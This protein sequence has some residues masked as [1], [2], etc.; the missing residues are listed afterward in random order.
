LD[1]RRGRL[2]SILGPADPTSDFDDPEIS[3]HHVG[4]AK[5]S[6]RPLERLEVGPRHLDIEIFGDQ[7]Q[8]PIAHAATYEARRR[9][10]G[11]TASSIARSSSGIAGA[12]GVI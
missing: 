7:P 12:A 4:G 11:R 8:Q 9:P 3:T 5:W 10:A 1:S 2:K 6:E